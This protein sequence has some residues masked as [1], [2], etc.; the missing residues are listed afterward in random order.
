MELSKLCTT[1]RE[2]KKLSD[3]RKQSSTRDAYKYTC[4]SC[5][6]EKARTRYNLKKEKIKKT[7]KN[8]QES[9]PEK[10][11]K[12]KKDYYHRKKM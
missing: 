6:S 12:Y 4:K 1:C 7:V 5:D 2:E 11:K 10:V 9:N 8:W 3:F